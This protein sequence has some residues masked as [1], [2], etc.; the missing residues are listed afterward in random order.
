MASRKEN[1]ALNKTQKCKLKRDRV[2][3]VSMLELKRCAASNNKN[4]KQ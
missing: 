1:I 3:N 4:E 2:I